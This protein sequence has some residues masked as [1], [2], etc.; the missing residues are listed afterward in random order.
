MLLMTVNSCSEC[1]GGGLGLHGSPLHWYKGLRVKQVLVQ[2][3]ANASQS[4]LRCPQDPALIAW[5]KK[6]ILECL[7]KM[8]KN[9]KQIWMQQP[10]CYLGREKDIYQFR[11]LQYLLKGLLKCCS[12]RSTCTYYVKDITSCF[13]S[14]RRSRAC[15]FL[16]DTNHLPNSFQKSFLAV[17][18]KKFWWY[19]L[20]NTEQRK[21]QVI[22]VIFWLQDGGTIVDTNLMSSNFHWFLTHSWL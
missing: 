22:K 14:W 5:P 12:L 11:E 1:R 21:C 3:H 6:Q 19:S 18:T 10:V 7:K 13:K 2:C 17:S 20:S 4:A 16:Y 15:L 9:K 8:S